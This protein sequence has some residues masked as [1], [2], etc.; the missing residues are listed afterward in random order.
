MPF[1]GHGVFSTRLAVAK[2]IFGSMKLP[3]GAGLSV[4]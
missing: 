3:K 4:S 2:P 1:A